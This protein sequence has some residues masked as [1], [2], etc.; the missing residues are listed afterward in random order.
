M[1]CKRH[2]FK[3]F[4]ETG[5]H[6]GDKGMRVA[7][8][9]KIGLVLRGP[10]G[11]TY[12]PDRAK[13]KDVWFKVGRDEREGKTGESKVDT[14]LALLACTIVYLY[15][16]LVLTA[17]HLVHS[18]R[19]M[20]FTWYKVIN[21]NDFLHFLLATKFVVLQNSACPPPPNFFHFFLP[22]FSNFFSF[23]A[24]KINKQTNKQLIK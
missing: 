16:L 15:Y 14:M 3:A 8:R 2:N 23:R 19:L 22:F 4:K 11:A 12:S 20:E 1:L 7:R 13:L 9:L 24:T 5:V 21:N 17:C 10:F 6:I 18:R